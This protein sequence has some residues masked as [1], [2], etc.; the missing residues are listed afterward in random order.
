MLDIGKS[1]EIGY[2]YTDFHKKN[3]QDLEFTT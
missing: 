2:E 1:A 3:S